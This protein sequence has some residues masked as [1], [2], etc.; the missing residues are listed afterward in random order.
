VGCVRACLDCELI[1]H[2]SAL[3][4]VK[5]QHHSS[6]TWTVFKYTVCINMFTCVFDGSVISQLNQSYALIYMHLANYGRPNID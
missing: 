6:T 4:V 1:A 2:W 5:I 3:V